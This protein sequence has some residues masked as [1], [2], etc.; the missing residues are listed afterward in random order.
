LATQKTLNKH[1]KSFRKELESQTK[2][3]EV[4]KG[5]EHKVIAL[6]T[7]RIR[8]RSFLYTTYRSF[9]LNI[10]NEQVIAYIH[11]IYR[12]QPR[13]ELIFMK[14]TNDEWAFVLNHHGI[15]TY[16]NGKLYGVL[17][18]SGDF[19]SPDGEMLIA[20]LDKSAKIEYPVMFNNK[21]VAGIPQFVD[22]KATNP[23][24]VY[25]YTKDLD[26]EEI[27]LVLSL[28]LINAVQLLD[29]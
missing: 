3:L 19:V 9:L 8:K 15:M 5:D 18:P 22:E 13:K 21:I 17:L 29:R 6:R 1:L 11:R 7:S 26:K 10:Y 27:H 4:W 25:F 12:G 2:R 24:A 20:K 14:S 23:R 28:A 16:V